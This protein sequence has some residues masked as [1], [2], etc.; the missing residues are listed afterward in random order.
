MITGNELTHSSSTCYILGTTST[1]ILLSVMLGLYNGDINSVFG[2]FICFGHIIVFIS[3]NMHWLNHSKNSMRAWIDTTASMIV[4]FNISWYM[5]LNSTQLIQ[6]ISLFLLSLAIIFYN[7]SCKFRYK[8]NYLI[9]LGCHILF[10]FFVFWFSFINVAPSS[11][12]N[13]HTFTIILLLTSVYFIHIYITYKVTNRNPNFKL[14]L[15]TMIY[16][17]IYMFLIISTLF[18]LL[19]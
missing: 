16:G 8:Y 12:I 18:K 1:W 17:N 6:Y 2:Y 19:I 5:I 13:K 10:R 3:S 7:L 4:V 11:L 14:T 9:G 15:S